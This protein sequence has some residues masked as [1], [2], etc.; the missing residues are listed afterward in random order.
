MLEK[1]LLRAIDELK[2]LVGFN[3][4]LCQDSSLKHT[5]LGFG[6]QQFSYYFWWIK[7]VKRENKKF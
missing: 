4:Y 2:K 7:S 3:L 5:E 1:H 6:Q